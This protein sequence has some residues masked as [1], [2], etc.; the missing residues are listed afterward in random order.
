MKSK[1]CLWALFIFLHIVLHAQVKIGNNST[2]INSASLL[3]LETTNKGFVLPRVSL[4]SI[5]SSSP[6]ASGLLTGT[7]IYNT[8]SSTT[9]GS[10]TG[11]YYWDGSKW[12]FLTNASTLNY[13]ALTGN[14]GTGAST[15][16]IGT[17][18][19]AGFRIRTNNIERLL[20]DSLGDIGIGSSAFNAVNREKLLID[21]GTTTSHTL[22]NLK[23]SINDYFQVNLQN[24]NSG[25]SASTDYVATADDGTDST[26]YIDMG[27]N[28]STYARAAH[29]WG[30]AHDSYLYT[31]SRNLLIGTATS[32]D[33][34]FMTGGGIV[35]SN[36][37]LR[38]KASTGNIVVGKGDN[39]NTPS[40][41]NIRGPNGNGSNIAGGSLTLNGG[42]ATDNAT[43][44][45]ININGGTSVLGAAGN[46]NINT[47]VSSNTYLNTGTSTGNIILG[48]SLNNINIP[49]LSASSVVLTDASKNLSF[50]TPSSN[51]YLF[52]N[53]SGFTWLNS[54]PINWSLTGN[55]GTT[56]ST[57][58]VGTT[59]AVDFVTKTNNIERIHILGAP[60]GS[61]KE[62]WIGMG[63]TVPRSSLDITGDFTNKNVVTVQ[64]TSNSGYSSVDM[65][66]NSGTLKGTFGY[67]NSGT[68]T[69]FGSRDYFST[70]GSDFVLN[71][72]S[73][74]FNLFMKGTTGN[75]GI[76]T[77]TP[78]AMLDVNGN[79]KLGSSGT[80]L[81][82]V[83]KT[84]ASITIPISA[85]SFSIS[86]TVAVSNAPLN[87][88]VIVNPRSALPAG[89]NIAYS[90]VSSA[91]VVTVN[92][93]GMLAVAAA[94]LVTF[95]I[96][97]LY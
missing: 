1:H 83:Y 23:G 67:G 7:I 8:N 90:Y 64:N 2:T 6:L 35:S 27:I 78:G 94:T 79:F 14:S 60:S 88:S 50:T 3:E 9:G 72:T 10:G 19:N 33:I 75:I 55:S 34:V 95:D 62:G 21:Y 37:I 56:A 61:S 46:V 26:Y 87:S 24:Y 65:L 51:T 29:N 58:F 43:G 45:S 73:G 4:T 18:D 93:T 31:N 49:K 28:S 52:Y 5:I 47:D 13:W 69:F 25:I 63:V 85:A 92:F 77:G 36:S 91:N 11:V 84:S 86:K 80:V 17:T 81:N 12:N 15:N 22:A 76:N 48:N 44:G 40:G 16:F 41:N 82:N 42:S 57:N 66:D 74:T 54:S 30:G 38:L 70:Y 39:T 97:V 68:G 89:V 53:G 20:I 59:D 71:T 32:N 96:T